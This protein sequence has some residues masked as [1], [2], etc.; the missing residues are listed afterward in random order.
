[1]RGAARRTDTQKRPGESVE[2]TVSPLS[3]RGAKRRG[4]RRECLWCNPFPSAHTKK[5]RTYPVGDGVL[6]V[7]LVGSTTNGM[8]PNLPPW[9]RGTAAKRWWK[10]NTAVRIRGNSLIKTAPASCASGGYLSVLTE[11][12]ERAT[13]GSAFGNRQSLK[14]IIPRRSPYSL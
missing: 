6:D 10:R 11:R 2:F 1:M 13:K 12:Y 9:G 8:P 4:D 5:L 3:L 7:P 14:V